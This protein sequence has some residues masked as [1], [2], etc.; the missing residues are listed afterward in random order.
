VTYRLASSGTAG[1]SLAKGASLKA[2][3]GGTCRVTATK[4]GDSNYLVGLST[5]AKVTFTK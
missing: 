5:T 4:A 2:K 1:C 3:K